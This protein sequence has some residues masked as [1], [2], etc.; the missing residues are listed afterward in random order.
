MWSLPACQDSPAYPLFIGP[1]W[2]FWPY[3]P[4]T[5]C[6]ASAAEAGEQQMGMTGKEYFCAPRSTHIPDLGS[7]PRHNW[8]YRGRRSTSRAAVAQPSTQPPS[9]RT[10]GVPGGRGTVSICG[11]LCLQVGVYVRCLLQLLFTLVLEI[12][13]LTGTGDLIMLGRLASGF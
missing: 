2:A 11:C 12:V 13:F 3:Q 1:Q 4:E 5:G 9:Q 6:S 10:M 8:R 7:V